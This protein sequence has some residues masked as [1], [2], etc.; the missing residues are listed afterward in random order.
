MDFALRKTE[1]LSTL[2]NYI[3]RI[4]VISN[5]LPITV[6]Y[7]EK[8]HK[9]SFKMSSGGL[10]AGLEGVKKKLPF[11]WV[12]WPGMEIPEEQ[13]K[14]FEKQLYDEFK[15][16][17]IFLDDDLADKHYNGFSNGVLWPLF[18]YLQEESGSNF[19]RELWKAYVEA[20]QKFADKIEKIWRK[21]DL[22]WVHDYHLMKMPH[23]LKK[24]N[25]NF[26]IGFFLH[27][28][29]PSSE[30]FR[31]LPVRKPI[32]KGVLNSD[33][34]GFHTFDY[35]RHF[36]SSCTRIL[37]LETTPGGIMYNGRYIPIIVSPVGI[38]PEKFL[39][40][41]KSEEHQKILLGYKKNFEGKK[42]LLGV[43]RLDYIKGIPHR[44]RAFELF[45]QKYPEWKGKVFLIQI[46]VPSRTEVEEYKKLKNEVDALV[47]HINGTYGTFESNPVHYLFRSVNF[48]EL[49]ALY[50]LSDVAIITSIRDGMNLVASEYIACQLEKHG[51]LILSEFA[52]SSNSLSGA[53]FVN[54]WNTEEVAY[55]I[56]DA[57]TMPNKIREFR[58]KHLY[59]FISTHT[60]SQWGE[61]FIKELD[62]INRATE[63]LN[64][65]PIL[66][67]QILQESFKKS[68]KRLLIFVTDGALIPYA[69]SPFLA[70]PS[71]KI[72]EILTFLNKN[73]KNKIYI[74][75][76]RERN[77]LL[78]W[79]GGLNIGLFAEYGFFMCESCENIND[80]NWISLDYSCDL[81][82]KQTVKPIFQHFTDRTP[83]S[84]FEEK[85]T[86]LTWHYRSTEREFGAFR[87]QEL[88]SHL[89]IIISFFF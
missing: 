66:T 9:W 77:T 55:A 69:S 80:M 48:Q 53:I 87:A 12:G 73:E 63:I 58:H 79:F 20:N 7:K 26:R 40:Q 27:I 4:I 3:G 11:V 16:I 70:N 85:E 13:K 28:P 14:E 17:P 1:S 68:N 38:D 33:L 18:H 31:I 54:P 19:S 65:T 51:V 35:A 8:D 59:K 62:R 67:I 75:S 2:S 44:L 41:L 78:R 6:T 71:R 42:V 32:L 37:G 72:R 50:H 52:G 45:L 34:I 57:L 39:I 24:K 64:K 49:C 86:S 60:A 25:F 89:G 29:F 84:Y 61:S 21:G 15:C 56:Y 81:S 46:A 23:L 22:I 83:G 30:I 43:D 47:A 74:I 76:G 82:W 88:Q 5:R 36:L 10:V